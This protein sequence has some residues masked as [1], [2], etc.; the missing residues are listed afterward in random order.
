MLINHS[1]YKAFLSDPERYRL[2]YELDHPDGNISGGI[3]PKKTPG[4]LADGSAF[5][6]YL[7]AH[8]KD[9]S[10]DEV[11]QKEIESGIAADNLRTGFAL[12]VAFTRRYETDKRFSIHRDQQGVFS[13][14]EFIVPIGN[15]SPHSI[16]GKIDELTEYQD[17]KH[18]GLWIGDY[19]SANNKTSENKKKIEFEDSQ[20]SNFY[21]NAMRLMEID[22][23]GMVYRVITKHTPPQHYV[24]PIRRT[25]LQLDITLLN[26]HQV[27][28][29]IQMMKNTFGVHV[30]WPHTRNYPCNY[31][32]PAGEIMCDYQTICSRP[33]AELMK[34]DFELFNPRVSHLE[35]NR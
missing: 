18:P 5:H 29:Q 25:K 2:E 32:N 1:S 11:K 31:R 3:S 30:P 16:I 9:W 8:N 28:E 12:A 26:I 10:A 17:A 19:K 15:G 24:I 22:V 34:E 4:P 14:R 23:K 7:E 35:V 27:A 21:L 6:F 33:H 20:Q 13:E